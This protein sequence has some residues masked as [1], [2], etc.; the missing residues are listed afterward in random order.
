MWSEL[1]V[2]TEHTDYLPLSR[3]IRIFGSGQGVSGRQQPQF[4]DVFGKAGAARNRFVGIGQDE[5]F[6]HGGAPG[7]LSGVLPFT[8]D[9]DATS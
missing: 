5:F 9:V 4:Q 8:V 7:R 6:S 2:P 3:Y 1:G